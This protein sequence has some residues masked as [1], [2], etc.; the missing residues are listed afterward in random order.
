MSWTCQQQQ[1]ARLV[2][3]EVYVGGVMGRMCGWVND[4]LSKRWS[5]YQF[6]LHVCKSKHI[7]NI[8]TFMSRRCVS[9]S[10]SSSTFQPLSLFP[11]TTH[12]TTFVANGS[13]F[14]TRR[15]RV[16]RHLGRN[17]GCFY[18]D[19]TAGHMGERRRQP[20]N[21][22]T[23]KP[24]TKSLSDSFHVYH[25]H[26]MTFSSTFISS[27]SSH[28]AHELNSRVKRFFCANSKQTT[29]WNGPSRYGR[30]EENR[31]H[32]ESCSAL[33]SVW[34][35]VVFAWRIKNVKQKKGGKSEEK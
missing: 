18:S 2:Q 35:G 30:G 23:E 34:C 28:I 6:S 32:L 22:E 16:N 21:T 15:R 25:Q 31:F 19:D 26:R 13:G 4:M 12:L 17:F 29:T 8:Y 7:W 10:D 9:D 5:T 27:F 14:A 33:S 3:H 11:E 1:L 20:V 24:P